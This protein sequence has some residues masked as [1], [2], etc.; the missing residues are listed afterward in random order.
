LHRGAWINFSQHYHIRLMTVSKFDIST[1]FFFLNLLHCNSIYL[2]FLPQDIK[3]T[4]VIQIVRCSI[5]VYR[6][7]K[8]SQCKMVLLWQFF[9]NVF[10]FFHFFFFFTSRELTDT[11][12]HV[13]RVWTVSTKTSDC[14]FFNNNLICQCKIS[15]GHVLPDTF[16]TGCWVVFDTL[17]LSTDYSIYFMKKSGS[18]RIWPIDKGCLLYLGTPFSTSG[19]SRFHVCPTM[20]I[21]HLHDLWD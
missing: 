5:T 19:I 3:N 21:T 10:C 6:K 18:L 13:T 12:V 4:V 17:I 7:D 20:Y 15:L 16:Y 8:V 11:Q 2:P 1:I 14:L 9:F